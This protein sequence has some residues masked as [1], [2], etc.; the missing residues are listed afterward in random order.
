MSDLYLFHKKC[1]FLQNKW[2]RTNHTLHSLTFY[3]YIRLRKTESIY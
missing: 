3:T 1:V 2:K